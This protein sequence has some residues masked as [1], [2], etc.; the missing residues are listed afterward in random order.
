[1]LGRVS[2]KS[3]GRKVKAGSRGRRVRGNAAQASAGAA[4]RPGAAR[5]SP[6]SARSKF[7]DALL[8]QL[9][10]L[11]DPESV[12]SAFQAEVATSVVLGNMTEAGTKQG[13]KP[14]AT[15]ELL[16]EAIRHVVEG[17]E[18]H[19]P[20]YAYPVLQALA[21]LAPPEV[22]EYA[23]EAAAELAGDRGARPG[24][25][26]GT[27]PPAGGAP[28]W[29]D[30]LARVTPG[31]CYVT[32]DEFGETLAVR[33]E[34]SYAGS[35]EP[36]CVFG[37]IDRAWH[38]AVTTLVVSDEPGDKQLRRMA[39]DAKRKGS[40]VREVSHAEAG[41]LLRDAIAS[42]WKYGAGPGA[43]LGERYGLLCSSLAIASARA[44]ALA[45]GAAVTDAAAERW[46]TEARRAL[47]ED[48]LASPQAAELRDPIARKVPHMLAMCCVGHLGCEPVL[49]GP[50][51]LERV[52]V[53]ALPRAAIAPDRFGKAVPQAVRAWT[54]W[55]AERNKLTDRSRRRLGFSLRAT[56]VRF[57]G[58]WYGPGAQ[59]LRRYL[60]DLNDEDASTGDVVNAVIERRVFA[61]P[62]PVE[63]VD[64]LAEE[65][66]GSRR[67]P[68]ELDAAVQSDRTL[69]TVMEASARGVS[70]QRF[71]SFVTVVQQLW[72]SDPPEV[73]EAAWRLR[74]A[75]RSRDWVLDRLARTWDAHGGDD[76]RYVAALKE[77]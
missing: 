58:A 51:V 6:S 4:T 77:L 28:P 36:H 57:A 50:S 52:L 13:V 74:D 38:G 71:P 73:W 18:R 76:E 54:D 70:Q 24:A 69:I 75:G 29:V 42:F 27:A 62:L 44:A 32:E 53:D 34:F 33:C 35:A 8:D 68:S 40:E 21:V 67:E 63:R 72:D 19:T 25:D 10:V 39:K 7:A 37:V 65:S 23:A 55:L 1:M 46:P 15:R 17:L 49:I 12:P 22:V 26:D 9:K 3:R 61:V 16:V 41:G 59:P 60:E 43:D 11:G 48:F 14:E 2:P 66:D 5:R 64:G 30:D 45:P 31:A 47:V 56:L 20:P